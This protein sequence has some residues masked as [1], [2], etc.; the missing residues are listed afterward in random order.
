[1]L[2]ALLTAGRQQTR[3]RAAACCAL[4]SWSPVQLSDQPV[5][6]SKGGS[7]FGAQGIIALAQFSRFGAGDYCLRSNCGFHALCSGLYP[8]HG[9]RYAILCHRRILAETAL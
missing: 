4:T 6:I 9:L 8:G 7:G 3:G 5:D 1:M 2:Q